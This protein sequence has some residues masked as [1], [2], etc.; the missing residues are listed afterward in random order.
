MRLAK[1]AVC[2]SSWRRV[3]AAA[4]GKLWLDWG[5]RPK[6]DLGEGWPSQEVVAEVSREDGE[7]G[8]AANQA[9]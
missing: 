1:G 2:F 9:G 7:E 4:V 5:C 3:G 8:G 6:G